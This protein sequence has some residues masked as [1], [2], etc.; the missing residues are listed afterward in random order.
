MFFKKYVGKNS[1][2]N[3]IHHLK[4]IH[5]LAKFSVLVL[6]LQEWKLRAPHLNST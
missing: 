4:K 1:L 3:C 6:T 2:T 5:V